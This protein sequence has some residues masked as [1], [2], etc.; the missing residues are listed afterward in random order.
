MGWEKEKHD[1]E[2]GAL[3]QMANTVKK[4]EDAYLFH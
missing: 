3:F 1:D 4:V 2:Q